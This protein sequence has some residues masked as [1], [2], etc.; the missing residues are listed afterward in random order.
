MR[1]R[2]SFFDNLWPP[3]TSNA[4]ARLTLLG[5]LV[6][7]LVAG[8]FVLR[9]IGGSPEELERERADL[10]TQLTQRRS[11]LERTKL[12]VARVETGRGEGDAFMQGFFLKDRTAYLT[13]LDELQGA[14]KD[15]KVTAKTHSFGLEPIEGSDNLSMMVITGNYEG[16]YSD[17]LNF[18][19]RLDR[20]PRLLIVESLNATPQQGGNGKLDITIKMDAFVRE[21]AAG[22]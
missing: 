10:R 17:L 19:N 18:V 20:S 7:N 6:A 8:W 4:I 16:A 22:L 5:L 12:N 1:R 15:S 9:P 13:I 2:F 14:A 3:R 21:G 11:L